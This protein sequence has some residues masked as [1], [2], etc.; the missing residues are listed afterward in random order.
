M[1]TSRPMY[2][3]EGPVAERPDPGRA[4]LQ[5]WATDEKR[6]YRDDGV[7]WEDVTGSRITVSAT[8]PTDP[9]PAVNDLWIDI[10]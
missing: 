9:A 3:T 8:Q 1:P 4:G 10:S 7:V 2:Y 5:Y 6:M